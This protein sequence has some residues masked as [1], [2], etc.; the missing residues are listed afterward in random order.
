M[1][2]LRQDLADPLY[3]VSDADAAAASAADA[4]WLFEDSVDVTAGER[5]LEEGGGIDWKLSTC[6]N[7]DTI[8][9]TASRPATSS[10]FTSCGT[11]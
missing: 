9:F 11:P 5:V 1:G 10:S 6:C 2:Y 7:T 3:A 8:I 4:P